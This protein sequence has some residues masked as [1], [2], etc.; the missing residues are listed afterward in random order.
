MG[1]TADIPISRSDVGVIHAD[2]THAIINNDGEANKQVYLPAPATVGL[3]HTLTIINHTSKSSEVIS[4]TA[5]NN[6]VKLNGTTTSTAD[7]KTLANSANKEVLI[8]AN[9]VFIASVISANNW[10]VFK[11]GSAVAPVAPN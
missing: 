3:G 1:D 5:E 8:D 9:S 6:A 10:S 11:V 2:T 4:A 7:N